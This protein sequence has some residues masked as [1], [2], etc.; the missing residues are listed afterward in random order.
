MSLKKRVGAGLKWTAFSQFVRQFLQWSTT[1]ILARLLYP[2]D[3][4][5]LAM[6]VVV[7]NFI[8]IFKG[9]GTS[10]AVIQRQSISEN[11]LSS[12]FWLNLLFGLLATI[13]VFALSPIIAL[14]FQEPRLTE[15]LRVLS[16]SFFLASFTIVQQAMLEREFAFSELAKI[17]LIAVVVASIVGIGMAINGAGV[18]SLVFKSLAEVIVIT[19]MFWFYSSWKPAMVFQ[20]AEIKSIASFSLNLTGFNILNYFSRNADNILIGRCLGAT[21]LGYY[22]LAYRIIFFPLQNITNAFARVTFP[23]LSRLQGNFERFRNAYLNIAGSIAVITFPLMLGLIA[24]SKIF[25]LTI[26]GAK[27]EPVV[28][29]I[30]ILE[31]VAMIQSV[32]MTSGGIFQATGRTDLML[33]WGLFSSLMY[34]TSFAIGVQWG[35]VG[36]ALAYAI[37]VAL[38]AYPNFAISFRLIDLPVH[39]LLVSLLKPFLCSCLMFTVVFACKMV[40]PLR[41]S[42][43]VSLLVLVSI[44]CIIYLAVSWFIN[45]RMVRKIMEIAGVK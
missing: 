39:K 21:D 33:R 14:F 45:N 35:I 40:M 17:E 22:F 13:I 2:S 25:V 42:R 44:G 7:T 19:V 34:I 1:A 10:A 28:L 43:P 6:A 31:L 4:G 11:L 29:L 18:W 5:L 12:I 9:L 26:F 15:I 20:L 32:G 36:V 30:I 38:L 16:L 24:T 27:W 41:L 8:Q 3:Y 37:A 23:A